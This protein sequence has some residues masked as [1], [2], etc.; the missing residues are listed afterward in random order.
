M[1]NDLNLFSLKATAQR[2]STI[3]II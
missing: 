3:Y 2:F 1:N